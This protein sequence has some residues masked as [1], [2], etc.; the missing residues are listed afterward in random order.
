MR[1]YFSELKCII[2]NKIKQQRLLQN[3]A[4]RDMRIISNDDKEEA[5]DALSQKIGTSMN[6]KRNLQEPMV[7][8]I[9]Q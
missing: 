6:H 9:R 2:P 7:E 1:V 5:L 8:Y 3:F 4:L